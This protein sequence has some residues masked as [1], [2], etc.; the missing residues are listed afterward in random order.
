MR[1]AS[2]S[3][4]PLL[5]QL[6][7][8]AHHHKSGCPEWVKV[9]EEV[10]H[11]EDYGDNRP[12]EER[13]TFIAAKDYSKTWWGA[14]SGGGKGGIDAPSTRLLAISLLGRAGARKQG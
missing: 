12:I 14:N 10:I 7:G 8:A 13:I 11:N 3:E 6:R 5:S 1:F 9:Y 2:Y 4:V